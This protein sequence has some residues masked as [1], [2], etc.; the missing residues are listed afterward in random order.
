VCFL[1]VVLFVSISQVIAAPKMTYIVSGGAL[2]STQ[3]PS[4]RLVTIELFV[5]P[6]LNSCT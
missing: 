2:N 4:Q 5:Y 3:T 6:G 1:C